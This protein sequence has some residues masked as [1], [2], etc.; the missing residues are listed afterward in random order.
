MWA[1][2]GHGWTRKKHGNLQ[3]TFVLV[4]LRFSVFL[5]CRSVANG[6]MILLLLLLR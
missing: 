5:P 3:N 6:C 4:L 1:I 2:M